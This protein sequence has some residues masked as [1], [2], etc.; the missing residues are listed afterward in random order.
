[1]DGV[2]VAESSRAGRKAYSCESIGAFHRP[3]Y[4]SDLTPPGIPCRSRKVKVSWVTLPPAE[5]RLTRACS[6]IGIRCAGNVSGKPSPASGLRTG[7]PSRPRWMLRRTIR[8]FYTV[9][10]RRSALVV[11]LE[12]TPY[13]SALPRQ[14][15]STTDRVQL[16]DRLYLPPQPRSLTSPTPSLSP[17]NST[18][19]SSMTRQ[20]LY[21]PRTRHHRRVAAGRTPLAM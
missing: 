16:L 18:T 6:A 9:S 11:R 15:P 21:P 19:L 5:L 14:L 12:L 13:S 7:F 4:R 17:N 10:A 8:E 1:M 2:A 20:S 3:V